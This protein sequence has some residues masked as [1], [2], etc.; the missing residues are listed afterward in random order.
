MNYGATTEIRKNAPV[1]FSYGATRYPEFPGGGFPSD[2]PE[3]ICGRARGATASLGTPDITVESE[4]DPPVS[5][6]RH[7]PP[8][9]L[10]AGEVGRGPVGESG[11]GCGEIVRHGPQSLAGALPITGLTPGAVYQI[12]VRAVGG[13]T[14]YSEWSLAVNQHCM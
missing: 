5:Y 1:S 3:V 9:L 6:L 8:T 7:L 2:I 13:S 14:G 4:N 10:I 11:E 12:Q